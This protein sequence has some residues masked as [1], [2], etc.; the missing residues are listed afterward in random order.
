VRTKQD[1]NFI[2]SAEFDFLPRNANSNGNAIQIKL[3]INLDVWDQGKRLPTFK[4]SQV[5][6]TRY[7]RRT[8]PWHSIPGTHLEEFQNITKIVTTIVKFIYFFI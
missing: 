5:E 1:F 4:S 8:S 2:L 3:K 7:P 6:P